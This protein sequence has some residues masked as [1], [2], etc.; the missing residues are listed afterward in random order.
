[1]NYRDA[2]KLEIYERKYSLEYIDH[3]FVDKRICFPAGIVRSKV[4]MEKELGQLLDAIW[5][6]IPL[7]PIYVS[8]QQN[9]DLLVLEE[10]DNLW[11]LLWFLE[12]R[13]AVDFWIENQHITDCTVKMLQ[14]DEPKLARRLYDTVVSFQII[15][16]R[17]PKYLHM[18]VGKF[19][20]HWS[21]TREQAIREI[22][23]D[24]YGIDLLHELSND[25]QIVLGREHIH[26]R[27]SNLVNRYRILYMIMNW[28]VYT[29][30]WRDD[31]EMQEQLVLEETIEAMHRQQ[32]RVDDLLDM[33][34][35]FSDYISYF[36]S[37]STHRISRSL[38]KSIQDKYLGLFACLMD[39]AHRRKVK[40]EY[41][42]QLLFERGVFYDICMELERHQLT[43][44]SI[45]LAIQKWE[46]EL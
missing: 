41:V 16:Y 24:S 44:Y 8:E 1:M 25:M 5:M 3:L 37:E 33:L 7:P 21:I 39:M 2:E 45:E 35:Y 10:N 9:G 18:S 13:Y 27:I 14:S 32:L 30:L 29:G 36:L 19:V 34:E 20:T 22:M 17:T 38:K 28:F 42:D 11:K 4:I 26:T 43:N 23:Y 12:G 15:D 6:G 46:R 31:I 40:R